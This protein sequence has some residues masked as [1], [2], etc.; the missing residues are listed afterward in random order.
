MRSCQLTVD[1]GCSFNQPQ[2]QLTLPFPLPPVG[3]ADGSSDGTADGDVEGAGV[4]L[5]CK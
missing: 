1:D 5:P 4:P 2:S 3:C